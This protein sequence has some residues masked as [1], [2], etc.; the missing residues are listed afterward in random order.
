L[1]LFFLSFVGFF[2]L[3]DGLIVLLLHHEKLATTAI[4]T[5]TAL[6]QP[7]EKTRKRTPKE[8]TYAADKSI[9]TKSTNQPNVFQYFFGVGRDTRENY[10]S[11]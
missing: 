10:R 4:V 1:V 7:F 3:F 5:R 8:N 6:L 2:F 11:G 9:L